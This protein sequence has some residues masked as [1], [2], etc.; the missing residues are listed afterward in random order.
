M[1]LTLQPL[2]PWLA[3]LGER[4]GRLLIGALL[5]LLTLLSALGLLTLSGWFITAT[6]VTAALG[7]G[8]YLDV[9]TPGSGIR[10]FAVSRT[11]SRY[12]ERLYNHDTV[13]RL[14]A[15]LRG[16]VFRGLVTL[17]AATLGRAR[18]S[19]WL[20]R[21]TADIDTLDNLYLRLLAPPL[22][23][24]IA[25]LGFAGFAM[26]FLPA[27]GVLLLAVL[28]PLWLVL[29]LGCA[30]WGWQAS[31]RRVDREER[32]RVRTI[33]QIDGL[34]ELRAYG[35][36]GRHQALWQAE[37]CEL[38]A[39]QRRL[40][41]RTAAANAL[42]TLGV[43]LAM[44]AVLL[45]GLFSFAAGDISGPVMVMMA[46]GTLAVSEALGNLPMA[47]TKLGA[48]VRAAQR[49]NA[50]MTLRTSLQGEPLTG[51]GQA[52][53]LDYRD[54]N[55]RLGGRNLYRYLSLSI[56][57]GER[58]G[59]I[60]PSGCGKSTLADLAVRA[61]DP[62]EGCVSFA[63]RDLVGVDPASLR[64]RIGYLTQRSE[65]F[66]DT[67][68]ANL[69]IGDPQATDADLWRALE[70]VEL[71]TWA[72]SLPSG[73]DTWL[74]EQGRQVS[75][76]Q[77]RRI[78]LARILLRNSPLVILDEPVSGLDS[79]TAARIKAM[80]DVW[81][82]GRTVLMLA[83]ARNAMPACDRIGRLSPGEEG[84]HWVEE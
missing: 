47:F 21:L 12:L 63:G 40:G 52:P 80:L 32:L 64:A 35:A 28:V 24:L 8:A 57:P 78:A 70:R 14:L 60:G 39:D 6:A 82:A 42:Q 38:L 62:D 50:Q 31:Y 55:V 81:L 68:A 2:K 36:T 19:E 61:F 76:G 41:W 51:G 74:G 25:I 5:M 29:T 58:V 71:K 72:D 53:G 59:I 9:F 49:L 37:E 48:T 65:L 30:C 56:H 13:L 84:A 7:A 66:H 54:I 4:R 1:A 3:V 11:L 15:D 77:A 34:A 23:A 45:I 75:G 44:L 10:F 22:A 17:D 26:A 20:N 73:L 33:E 27:A 46:L 67:L 43:Q 83:H 69:R 16:R 79:A 18:S